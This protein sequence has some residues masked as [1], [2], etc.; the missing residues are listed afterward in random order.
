MPL[1]PTLQQCLI[2]QSNWSESVWSPDRRY[3]DSLWVLKCQCSKIPAQLQST[4]NNMDYFFGM[5][6][7]QSI[8]DMCQYLP[9]SHGHRSSRLYVFWFPFQDG[10]NISCTVGGNLL[11]LHIVLWWCRKWR[12]SLVSAEHLL[13]ILSVYT[14]RQLLCSMWSPGLVFSW[15]FSGLHVAPSKRDSWFRKSKM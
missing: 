5:L 4:F 14:V 9:L 13:S 6:F 2:S 1:C 7:E 8:S 3:V 15:E 12:P 10:V 11:S